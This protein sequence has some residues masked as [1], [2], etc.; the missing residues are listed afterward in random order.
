MTDQDWVSRHA[1]SLGVFVNGKAIPGHD[2]HGKPVVDDS[3]FL[4]FNGQFRAVYWNLPREY[5]AGWRIILDTDRLEPEA[6]PQPVPERVLT[7][8]RTVV[9]LQG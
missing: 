5:E 7:R 8:A 4:L 1:R 9:L 2:D 3:F 6:E